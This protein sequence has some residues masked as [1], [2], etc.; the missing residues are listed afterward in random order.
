MIYIKNNRPTKTLP[1]NL[2]PYKAYTYE[3]LDLSYLQVLSWTIY[4]FLYEEKQMLKSEKWTPRAL[5][6]I[7]VSYNGHTIYW[8]YLKDQKKV[9]RVK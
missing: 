1:Q 7:L 9:I 6:E 4:V 5:K 2:S 8:V 3:P